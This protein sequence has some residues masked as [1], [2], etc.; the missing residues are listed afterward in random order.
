MYVC[1]YVCVHDLYIQYIYIYI[2]RGE[3]TLFGI[4]KEDTTRNKWL[5]CIFNTVPE[6]FNPN[7]RV[8]SAF[9]GELFPGPGRVANNAGLHKHLLFLLS[10][11][12]P[13][14]Q[15]Q[16]DASDSQPV[17]MFLLLMIQTGVLCSVE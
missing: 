14:L 11:A 3:R 16:S 7:I 1:V 9:H 15:G 2:C 6:Q 12:I 17:N 8:C 4:P 13:T 5:S 10:G